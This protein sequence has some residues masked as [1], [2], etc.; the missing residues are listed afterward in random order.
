MSFLIGIWLINILDISVIFLEICVLVYFYL[1][2]FPKKVLDKNGPYYKHVS[3]KSMKFLSVGYPGILSVICR[4]HLLFVFA[5]AGFLISNT[6][7]C[8]RMETLTYVWKLYHK[9]EQHLRLEAHIFIKLLQ[10]LYLIN[11]HILK[12]WHARCNCKLW[13]YCVFWVFS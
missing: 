11:K 13:F 9:N 1:L 10:N 4:R 7:F 6:I 2:R 8:H 12:Y 5:W 3:E